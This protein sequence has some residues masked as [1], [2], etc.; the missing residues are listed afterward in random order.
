M[1]IA[2]LPDDLIMHHIVVDRWEDGVDA[3]QNVVCIC[4]LV[5]LV[6]GETLGLRAD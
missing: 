2:G 3:D 5:R 6:T 1:L 4:S